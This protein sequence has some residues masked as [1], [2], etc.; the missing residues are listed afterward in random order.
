MEWIKIS[1]NN[2]R[3]MK[4]VLTLTI[5][6]DVC[7]DTRIAEVTEYGDWHDSRTGD[8]IEAPGYYIEI[9]P[10]P[11]KEYVDPNQTKLEFDESND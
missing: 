1:K 9:P 5:V 11:D 3:E 10:R 2:P 8:L 7:H 6:D 4:P